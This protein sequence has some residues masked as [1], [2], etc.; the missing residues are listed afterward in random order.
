M[1]EVGRGGFGIV[2]RGTY[3]GN[4]I[5]FKHIAVEES[6][7]LA[8]ERQIKELYREAYVTSLL[9]HPNV[10]S[11]FGV[12]LE[13]SHYGLVQEYYS[14]GALD[15]FLRESSGDVSHELYIPMG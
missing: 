5:A 8:A 15:D 10:C 14:G 9:R 7:K 1:E 3:Q 6:N 12:V 13:K 2:Y 11:L 4:A